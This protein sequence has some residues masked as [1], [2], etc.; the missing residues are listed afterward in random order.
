MEKRDQGGSWRDRKQEEAETGN[1]QE[2]EAGRI[3]K[4]AGSR[5]KLQAG[6][7]KRTEDPK[8]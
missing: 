3:L 6:E 5:Q 4:S 7:G 1:W 8:G 2:S